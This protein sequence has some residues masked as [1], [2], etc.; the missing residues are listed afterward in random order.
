[1]KFGAPGNEFDIAGEE[2]L[3]CGPLPAATIYVRRQ[4]HKGITVLYVAI[5]M[6]ALC[7]FC[8]LAVDLGRVELAKTEM[9][10]CADAAALAAL[11]EIRLGNGVSAAQTAAQA[12]ASANTV[13]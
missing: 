9:L 4:R 13:D 1:M 6:T 2:E 11:R 12:A 10:R 5:A 8:S 3:S 7:G